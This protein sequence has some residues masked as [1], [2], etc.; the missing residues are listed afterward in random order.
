MKSIGLN[1]L[2][3]RITLRLP[4]IGGF[5][6]R[7]SVRETSSSSLVPVLA[8]CGFSL[9]QL[10]VSST[11]PPARACCPLPRN[12]AFLSLPLTTFSAFTLRESILPLVTLCWTGAV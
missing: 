11:T 4:L 1:S 10:P 2:L 9:Y 8:S 7:S 12:R 6:L 3:P 5:L